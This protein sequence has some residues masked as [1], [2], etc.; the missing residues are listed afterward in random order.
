MTQPALKTATDCARLIEEKSIGGGFD[1]TFEYDPADLF[2]PR[3]APVQPTK[4]RGCGTDTFNGRR[5]DGPSLRRSG[6]LRPIPQGRRG[7]PA[8]TALCTSSRF[9]CRRWIMDDHGT[10]EPSR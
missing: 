9:S 2:A 3:A 7:R 6:G 8:P 1:A 5:V 10:W 4:G